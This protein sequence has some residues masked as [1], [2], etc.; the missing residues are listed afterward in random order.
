MPRFQ[1]ASNRNSYFIFGLSLP[2]GEKKNYGSPGKRT[3]T[4]RFDLPR[5]ENI[6]KDIYIW[7]V[8]IKQSVRFRCSKAV[9]KCENLINFS[10]FNERERGEES[11]IGPKFV[12]P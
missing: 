2:G 8:V 4:K 12:R 10:K 6:Y 7:S 9:E 1:E 11:A 5:I 3:E